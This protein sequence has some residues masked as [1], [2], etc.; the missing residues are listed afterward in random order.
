MRPAG[1]PLPVTRILPSR[2]PPLGYNPLVSPSHR[3]PSDAYA[4]AGRDPGP[5]VPARHPVPRRRRREGNAPAPPADWK[6][7]PACRLVST[8]GAAHAMT[9]RAHSRTGSEADQSF[10]LPADFGGDFVPL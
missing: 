3:R 4:F 2:R 9:A 6:E 8:G 5:A 10:R 7:N 1:A